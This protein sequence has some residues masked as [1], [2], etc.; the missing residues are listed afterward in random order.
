[1]PKQKSQ[2]LFLNLFESIEKVGISGTNNILI[3]GTEKMHNDLTNKIDFIIKTITR[4]F[5]LKKEELLHA[6]T[7]HDRTDALAICFYISKQKLKLNGKQIAKTFRKSMAQVSRG[8]KRI[9]ELDPT[10][11]ADKDIRD[12]YMNVVDMY[13]KEFFD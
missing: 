8:I 3:E 2:E 7:K 4:I 10:H 12:K 11:P 13:D 1:M 5:G 9:K 6:L